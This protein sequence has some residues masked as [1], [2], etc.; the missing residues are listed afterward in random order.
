MKKYDALVGTDMDFLRYLQTRFPMFHQSNFF[1]RDIQFGVA[2][3]LRAK[4]VRVRSDEAEKIAR[5]Y[6]ERF[7]KARLFLPIDR[8]TWAVNMPE[9]RTPQVQPAP[10]PAPK[11]A[12]TAPAPS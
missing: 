11:P 8:Q 6:V 12:V 10:K 4:G 3:L 5:R 7:E 1:F 9:F 2:D